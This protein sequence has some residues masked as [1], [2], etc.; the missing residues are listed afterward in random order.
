MLSR[1]THTLTRPDLD[2]MSGLMNPPS[3]YQFSEMFGGTKGANTKLDACFSFQSTSRLFKSNSIVAK[4]GSGRYVEGS[5]TKSTACV[6]QDLDHPVPR[7]SE[8]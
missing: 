7:P 2:R 1:P 5:K 4:D 3:S 8:K 6:L